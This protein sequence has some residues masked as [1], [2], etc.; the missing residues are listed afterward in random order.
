[1]H[2]A[3]SYALDIMYCNTRISESLHTHDGNSCRYVSKYVGAREHALR[4]TT[5]AVCSAHGVCV[6][7]A[8][9]CLLPPEGI[10]CIIGIECCLFGFLLFHTAQL[11]SKLLRR[12]ARKSTWIAG[13]RAC[14]RARRT[15]PHSALV[16]SGERSR[17]D[18]EAAHRV[19]R[20]RRERSRA[21]ASGVGGCADATS[22]RRNARPFDLC[23]S[24][25]RALR[26][27]RQPSG[28][29]RLFFRLILVCF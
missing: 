10:F 28:L 11:Y 6:G 12:P 16:C 15:R 20:C 3:Y 29:F 26:R 18:C 25:R 13:R 19:R 2:R 21:T 27:R 24:A 1:M 9:R 4:G 14:R 8:A 7:A 17:G 23:A 5:R 22:S